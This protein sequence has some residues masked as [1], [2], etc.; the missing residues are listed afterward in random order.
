MKKNKNVLIYIVGLFVPV[1]ACFTIIFYMYKDQKFINDKN[2]IKTIGVINNYNEEDNTA[3][4]T[5][6][7]EKGNEYS[8]RKN[9][10]TI[11][12]NLIFYSFNLTKDK[13]D[14]YY[15]KN[16]PND[17]IIINKFSNIVGLM[18]SLMFIVLISYSLLHKN[19]KGDY[20]L[21]EGIPVNGTII[22][23]TKEEVM[24]G[25]YKRYYYALLVSYIYNGKYY[26]TK[27]LL[28]F[29][30]SDVINKYNINNI[31]VYINERK[32]KI[33]YIDISKI[34]KYKKEEKEKKYEKI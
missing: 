6:K 27:R 19:K 17:F 2:T 25:Q 4:I 28:K 8:S 22:S 11:N 3:Y 24:K 26:E 7:D 18:I 14:V 1:L 9:Y 29:D 30:P 33:S 16:N 34:E 12:I 5:F 15:N 23:I 20:L 32:P 10:S 31:E 13:V 21:K